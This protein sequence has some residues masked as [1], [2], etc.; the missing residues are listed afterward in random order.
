MSTAP[1]D[2]EA[3]EDENLRLMGQV[4]EL[5][6]TLDEVMAENGVLNQRFDA[7]IEQRD[8]K[9]SELDNFVNKLNL[10]QQEKRE[11]E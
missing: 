6:D 10:V 4:R 11:V 8:A 1:V 2:W 5:T 9:Q 3:L 7:I